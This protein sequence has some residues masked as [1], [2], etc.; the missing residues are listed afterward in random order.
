MNMNSGTTCPLCDGPAERLQV[1][2]EEGACICQACGEYRFGVPAEAELSDNYED[3]RYLLSAHTRR[4]S[5][6]GN[7]LFLTAR[8]VEEFFATASGPRTPFEILEPLL[9]YVHARTPEPDAFVPVPRTDYP[10]FA[11]QDQHRLVKYLTK[12]EDMGLLEN[13]KNAKSGTRWRLNLPS[14]EGDGFG[15]RLKSPKEP[16]RRRRDHHSVTLKF[17]SSWGSMSCS[18]MYCFS[19]SS[20]TFPLVATK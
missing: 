5:D 10:L 16:R 7:P 1:S 19:T 3:R 8:F 14:P 2:G 17:S 12:L 4:H 20:V 9:L 15:W 6:G 18:S 13:T 11:L